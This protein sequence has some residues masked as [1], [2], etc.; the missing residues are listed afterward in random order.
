MK[1]VEYSDMPLNK[2]SGGGNTYVRSLTRELQKSG[3]KVIIS[4]GLNRPRLFS[5][6]H[7]AKI[8]GNADVHHFQEPSIS[9]PIAWI[10]RVSTSKCVLTFHAPVSNYLFRRLHYKFMRYVYG[11]SNLVL[12]SS[13]KNFEVLR[14]NGVDATVIPLWADDTFHPSLGNVYDRSPY[15]LSVCVAD[16]FHSYKNFTMISKIAKTLKE[17]F[18]ISCVHV[19]PREFNLPYVKHAGIVNLNQLRELYQNALTLILPSIG[20]YEGFGLV[21]AESLACATPVLV[22]DECGVADFLE[23]TFVSPLKFFEKRLIYMIEEM[24]KNPRDLIS[25][26]QSESLKF[27]AEPL[28]KT[29]QLII[30]SVV[31]S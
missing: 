24:L 8:Y 31:K 13:Y 14:A 23:K 17:R 27:G 3:H 1:I 9:F 11:K 22:S 20:P 21:A 12:T 26:A 2:N 18:N 5:N 6:R 16:N 25:K 4:D 28:K 30:E 19:G 10:N 29:T 7:I 15:V